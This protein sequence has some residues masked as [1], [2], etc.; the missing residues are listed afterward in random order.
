MGTLG[1]YRGSYRAIREEFT[2][3]EALIGTQD[4]ERGTKADPD[5]IPM[6]TLI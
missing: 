1:H 5:S 6:G 2:V 4:G 3:G